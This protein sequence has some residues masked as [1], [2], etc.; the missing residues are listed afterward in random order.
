M[1]SYPVPPNSLL[2]NFYQNQCKFLEKSVNKTLRDC[3]TL[4]S[5]ISNPHNRECVILNV[6]RLVFCS[7]YGRILEASERNIESIKP[8]ASNTPLFELPSLERLLKFF[9]SSESILKI[10][11]GGDVSLITSWLVL[12]ERF[13]V[14]GDLFF[15]GGR[16][17][18][19][20]K[21]NG[22]TVS[23]FIPCGGPDPETDQL[24]SWCRKYSLDDIIPVK[25]QQLQYR[26]GEGLLSAVS[27]QDWTSIQKG[28]VNEGD[29][30]NCRGEYLVVKGVGIDFNSDF[31]NIVRYK[32]DF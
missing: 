25:A 26:Q 23:V 29:Y 20:L 28:Q 21:V 11:S 17:V 15:E 1:A 2:I 4:K 13:N 5:N 24:P 8:S 10:H 14:K 18:I 27:K 3:S 7:V 6:S 19:P 22:D 12:K 32:T 9:K 30:V 16:L 31:K